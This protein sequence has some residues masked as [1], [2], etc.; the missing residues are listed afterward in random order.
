M[1]RITIFLFFFTFSAMAQI[2]IT[3][4]VTDYQDRPYVD[5]PVTNGRDTVRTDSKGRY[6]IEAKL[7]DVIYF[8]RLEKKS[9][10]YY[11]GIPYYVLKETPHQS[12]DAFVGFSS[13]HECRKG[14]RNPDILFV[15]D[16]VPIKAKDKESFKERLRNGEFYQYVLKE[17]AFFSDRI[18]DYYAYI[19]YV[20]TQ[21]YYN[22]HIK[23]KEKST[24]N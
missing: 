9:Q 20:Y 16:G 8:Y 7:W 1:T 17:D 12:Y 13:I 24:N 4:K 2:T 11:D 10:T 14:A 15:L 22:E 18:R 3:G 6:K 19:L 5:F 21:D 23:D